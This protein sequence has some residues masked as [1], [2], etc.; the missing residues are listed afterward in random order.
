MR[1]NT[2]GK[3]PSERPPTA[4]QLL[5]DAANAYHGRTFQPSQIREIASVVMGMDREIGRLMQVENLL[6]AYLNEYGEDLMDD[7]V[8]I[9]EGEIEDGD[10]S[11]TTLP[12][13][14]VSEEDGVHPQVAEEP[15]GQVEVPETQDE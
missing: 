3:F 7:L 2:V 4:M 11:E 9:V 1:T 10:E 15:V 14:Q 8:G 6:A 13:G 12:E 5:F